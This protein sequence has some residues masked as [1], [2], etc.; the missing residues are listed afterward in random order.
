[1]RISRID[2]PSDFMNAQYYTE[3]TLGSPPQPV[4]H[5]PW[6]Y[7]NLTSKSSSKLFLTLDPATSGSL[8]PN[9]LPSPASFTPSMIRRRRP[10][11]KPMALPLKFHMFLGL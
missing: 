7:T 6:F 9:A 5:S 4:C 1:M 11:T 3:I 10:R 2:E 8:A